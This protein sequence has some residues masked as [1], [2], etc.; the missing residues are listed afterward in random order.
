MKMDGDDSQ[1]PA[2]ERSIHS[3]PSV[4]DLERQ[5]SSASISSVDSVRDLKL[6]QSIHNLHRLAPFAINFMSMSLYLVGG[7]GLF[8]RQGDYFGL[9]EGGVRSVSKIGR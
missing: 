2:E 7:G 4:D 8:L 3:R 1:S 6:V 9:G 5:I